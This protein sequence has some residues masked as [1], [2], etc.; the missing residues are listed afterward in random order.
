MTWA[1]SSAVDMSFGEVP[2]REI[3]LLVGP[4][5]VPLAEQL[6]DLLFGLLHGSG[7]VAWTMMVG[8]SRELLAEEIS[9]AVVRGT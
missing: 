9:G 8:P 5:A 7:A 1:D 6:G 2:D 4:D 3:V